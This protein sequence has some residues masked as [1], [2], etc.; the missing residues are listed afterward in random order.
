MIDWLVNRIFRWDP[1]REAVT[2]EVHMYDQIG[3]T[4]ADPNAMKTASVIWWEPD[5]FHG[6][7][8]NEDKKRYFFN[9]I[10]GMMMDTL[11]LEW[12]GEFDLD[13]VSQ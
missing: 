5:G 9:D 11:N 10:G 4:L 12:K 1:L 7:V 6:W 3:R 2:D 8:Y 13:E